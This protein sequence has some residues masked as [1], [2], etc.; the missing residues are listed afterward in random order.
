MQRVLVAA[1]ALNVALQRA[2][3]VG[4]RLAGHTV[5]GLA[6]AVV[7]VVDRVEVVVLQWGRL[8]CLDVTML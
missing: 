3:H 7:E 1:R 4:R 6:G 2:L 8:G 5:P